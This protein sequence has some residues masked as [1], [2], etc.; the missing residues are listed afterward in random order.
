[1]LAQIQGLWAPLPRANLRRLWKAL[2]IPVLR[3]IFLRSIC[4]TILELGAIGPRHEEA[5]KKNCP[6][7]GFLQFTDYFTQAIYSI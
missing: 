5:R 3:P 7:P 6:T 4:A 1:M 2:Q